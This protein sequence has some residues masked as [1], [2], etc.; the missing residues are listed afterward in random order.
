M[1]A[2]FFF[3]CDD[4]SVLGDS[5]F[6]NQCVRGDVVTRETPVPCGVVTEGLITEWLP[7][8]VPVRCRIWCHRRSAPLSSQVHS[9]PRVTPAD[10]R[11]LC[12]S[13]PRRWGWEL[14]GPPTRRRPS[15]DRQRSGRTHCRR[16]T[17]TCE[18]PRRTAHSRRRPL[19]LASAPSLSTRIRHLTGS[20]PSGRSHRG[21]KSRGGRALEQPPEEKVAKAW[22]ENRRSHPIQARALKR[23]LVFCVS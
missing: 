21:T 7:R 14:R 20:R 2:P 22:P 6:F 17:R 12:C 8:V 18:S 19:Q 13:N 11:S 16:H 15:R 1:S 9:Q 23:H 3:A 4:R 10:L 5:K